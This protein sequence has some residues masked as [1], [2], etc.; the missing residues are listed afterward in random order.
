MQHELEAVSARADGI[1]LPLDVL[2]ATV[3]F[4]PLG[5]AHFDAAGRV[6]MANAQLC[7][8]LRMPAAKL[9]GA[10]FFDFTHPDDVADCQDLTLRV[11]AGNVPSYR[12][13]K[14]FVRPDGSVVWTCVT[15]SAARTEAGALLFLIG[16]VEDIS[17]R[18]EAEARRKE[19]EE[20]LTAALAA[21]CTATFRWDIG[22]DQVECDEALL[23][24]WE[25]DA[26]GPRLRAS[27][28][29]EH[30]HAE[31]VARV[32]AAIAAALHV[33]GSFREEF[34]VALRDGGVRWIR[35]VGR[36]LDSGDGSLHMVGACTD[37]T[38]ARQAQ[39]EIRASE[40]RLRTLAN[41]LPQ[42]VWIGDG[43]G[44]RTWFN[45]RWHEYTGLDASALSGK[46]WRQVQHPEH[47]QRVIEGQLRCFAADEVW[48]DSF[49]LR[50][51]DGSYRW[52]LGRAVPV[53]DGS[54]ATQE[55]F[56]SN[57]DVTQQMQALDAANAAKKLRDE[58]VA[59]VA[60]DLRN[61]VHTIALAAAALAA[62][63]LADAQRPRLLSTIRQTALNMG[64]LL[65]DL[66]D[67]SRMESGTFA[68][69]K[70]PIDARS[71]FCALLE[72]FEGRAKERGIALNVDTDCSLEVLGDQD[73]LAQVLSNLVGNALKFTPSGGK[74]EMKC[75]SSEQGVVFCV[76]DTGPGIPE[77]DL[78]RLFERFWR[79]DATSPGG[80]GLGLAI[81]RGIVEA[82]G[83]RIWVESEPGLTSF[84]FTVPHG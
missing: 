75:C 58:M 12:H 41:M 4:A 3:E 30:V 10:N 72:Q 6:L 63:R 35:D 55:W 77:A 78:P 84:R 17:E 24:L 79:A 8:I 53:R 45:E 66:L 60:H 48:E 23:H 50:A 1:A 14:R 37:V 59:V 5:I 42:L 57:T 7:G 21:S 56:G 46:G 54:G 11:A 29:T 67:V 13:E 33:G 34:R 43:T 25:I 52:F 22:R 44:R 82:H 39:E 9:I 65:D 38:E 64:R 27:D 81:A 26:K 76:H 20:R 83:G 2:R 28:F 80:A 47:A 32:N 71:L 15:V 69:A 70:R 18:R 36:V 40:R 73:R 62:D 19:A 49:P 68:V 31:D 61:P 51:A 74:V 16:M